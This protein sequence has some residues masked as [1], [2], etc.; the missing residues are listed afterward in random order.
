MNNKSE[1][2]I[3]VLNRKNHLFISYFNNL[4]DLNIEILMNNISGIERLLSNNHDVNEINNEG[5]SLLCEAVMLNNYDITKYLIDNG[6]DVNGNG[7]FIPLLIAAENGN[8][9]IMEL[10]LK[11][12]VNPNQLDI[13]G[14]NALDHLFNKGCIHELKWQRKCQSISPI[15]LRENSYPRNEIRCINLLNDANIDINHTT[16]VNYK[17]DFNKDISVDINALTI[18]LN[19]F[20]IPS[21]EVIKLLIKLGINL[22]IIELAPKVIYAYQ[23]SFSFIHDIKNKNLV[24]WKKAYFEYLEYLKYLNCIK[25]LNIEAYTINPYDGYRRSKLIKELKK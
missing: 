16:K 6:A 7:K 10:L 14:F 25:K 9:Q 11:N 12:N 20:P 23:D 22:Q 1:D 13:N 19:N 4:T 8:D 21:K 15:F 17:Y 18:A 5:I 3:K 2:I 24:A